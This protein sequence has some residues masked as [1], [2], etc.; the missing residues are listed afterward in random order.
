MSIERS[1][2]DFVRFSLG[3]QTL[4]FTGWLTTLVEGFATYS[5]SSGII[6]RTVAFTAMAN[7]NNMV[8]YN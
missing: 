6:S 8:F 1:V 5:S 4:S 7:I 3:N 2:N